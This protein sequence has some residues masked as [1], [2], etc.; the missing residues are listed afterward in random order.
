[1]VASYRLVGYENRILED[2]DFNDDA[3]DAGDMGA[4][5]SVTALYELILVGRGEENGPDVDPLKYQEAPRPSA[6][7]RRDE[8]MTVKVRYKAPDG[9][10]SSLTSAIVRRE[11]VELASLNFAAAVAE[12][13]MVL[14]DSAFKGSSSYAGAR[15]L[16]TRFK[17]DDRHG[18]R[19]EFIR[20]IDAAEQLSRQDRRD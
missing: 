10:V 17:G 18:H 1:V 16:A 7:A 19:A 20:L 11:S 12:F 9:V 6:A 3:K 5:H 13:G 8:A 4:G 15:L 14:R 2:R